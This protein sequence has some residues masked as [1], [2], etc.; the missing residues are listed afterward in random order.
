MA[1]F[2]N[3]ITANL[4]MKVE[5]NADGNIATQSE[6]GTG[7][8]RCSIDGIKANSTLSEATEV[9]KT[10]YMIICN[11]SFD[12]LSAEKTTVQEVENNG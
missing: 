1:E 5:T 2:E 7:V 8:K 12:S 3:A 9:F 10:F 11:A 6:I 4:S